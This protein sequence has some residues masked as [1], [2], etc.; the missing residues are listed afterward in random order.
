M[1]KI[2]SAFGF[3]GLWFSIWFLC[4]V[5]FAQPTSN[6]RVRDLADVRL[7]TTVPNGNVLTWSTSLGRWTNAAGGGGGI[8]GLSD[9]NPAQFTT[10]G[11]VSLVPSGL[12]IT[13]L[14]AANFLTANYA[15]FTNNVQ[16][17]GALVLPNGA[18]NGF[19]LTSD[20]SG[21]AS[22]KAAGGLSTNFFNTIVTTNL[23]ILNSLTVSN[24]SVTNLTVQNNLIV[25]NLY[26]VNG[27]HNTLT[28]TNVQ[29]IDLNAGSMFRVYLGANAFFPAVSNH[30]GTNLSQTIQIA[31]IQDGTGT[32]GITMTNSTWLLNGSGASTN[33]TPTINTNANAITILTFDTSPTNAVQL[34]GNVTTISP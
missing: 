10:N 22:W 15:E 1:K 21:T 13:N 16:I 25:S 14:Y 11:G 24:I 32:R 30:P 4:I 29:T 23:T 34:I 9:F 27:N 26:T 2:L 3:I 5:V 12:K 20:G 31:L 8:V 7:A 28:G 6:T 17:D 18:T 19:V 33:A